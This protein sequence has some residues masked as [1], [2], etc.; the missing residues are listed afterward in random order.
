MNPEPNEMNGANSSEENK[1]GNKKKG[2][3]N[4]II[5]YG[6]GFLASFGIVFASIFFYVTKVQQPKMV[7]EYAAQVAAAE[8]DSL[9]AASDSTMSDSTAQQIAVKDTTEYLSDR[10]EEYRELER[11]RLVEQVS[12]LRDRL[13]QS[14]TALE[15]LSGVAQ[16]NDSLFNEYNRL[17]KQYDEADEELKFLK[18]ALPENLDKLM[19]AVKDVADQKQTTANPVAVAQQP[20]QQQQEPAE[21]QGK[22][23]RKLAKI[24]GNMKPKEA[25]AIME[26]MS[27]REIVDIM[28]LMRDRDAAA[29]L[30]S[31]TDKTKA[32]EIS[33]RM[34]SE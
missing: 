25:S 20:V 28:I 18:E 10:E 22:G 15:E 2:K 11:M 31:F 19:K 9:L 16:M 1:A 30:A 29:I 7:E 6:I 12:I 23:L 24:Y 3:M 33:R 8:A 13:D 17:R 32:V 4:P 5:L 26:N 21:D 34:Q 14:Q 27:N